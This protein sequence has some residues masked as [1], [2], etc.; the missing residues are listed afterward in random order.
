[1]KI[2]KEFK[3][4]ALKGNVMDLAIAVVLAAAIGRIITALTASIIM[5]LISL[6]MGKATVEELIFV[7]GGTVF[8]I[9]L[10]LQA[11]FDFIIIAIVLFLIIKAVNRW[12]RKK[13][14]APAAAPELT[15]SEKLLIEI[16]DSVK[17]QRTV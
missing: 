3:E 9:G 15:L 5:P 16:R 4:F 1:M 17:N 12:N 11:I 13:E 8:P 10:L 7:V 14:E 6:V 2:V